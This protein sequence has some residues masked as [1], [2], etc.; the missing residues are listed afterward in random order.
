MAKHGRAQ[1][2]VVRDHPERPG[3]HAEVLAGREG[4]GA[5]GGLPRGV[6]RRLRDLAHQEIDHATDDLLLAPNVVIERHRLDPEPLAD[7]AHRDRLEPV[8]VRD[9]DRGTQHAL[10]AE[11]RACLPS[12]LAAR[13]GLPAGGLDSLTLYG[14]GRLTGLQC[15]PKEP[16]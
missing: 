12:A 2:R 6:R 16:M 8:L 5:D 7:S 10:A 1:A 13:G 3:M 9:L 15:K 11:R 14:Y 4:P